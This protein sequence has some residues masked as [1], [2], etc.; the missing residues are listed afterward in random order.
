MNALKL[1]YPITG[2]LLFTFLV[3]MSACD[4]TGSGEEEEEVITP[5]EHPFYAGY[6]RADMNGGNDYNTTSH[7]KKEPAQKSSIST[8]TPLSQ[9]NEAAKSSANGYYLEFYRPEDQEHYIGISNSNTET[10]SEISWGDEI[11]ITFSV[12][13][14]GTSTFSVHLG[15]Y[16]PAE[17]VIEWDGEEYDSIPIEFLEANYYETRGIPISDFWAEVDMS[18][19]THEIELTLVVPGQTSTTIMRRFQIAPPDI[20]AEKFDFAEKTYFIENNAE[21]IYGDLSVS[22]NTLYLDG[23]GTLE[24]VENNE[25][26]MIVSVSLDGAHKEKNV[27]GYHVGLK[28]IPPTIPNNAT[29]NL[30]VDRGWILQ[31]STKNSEEGDRWFFMSSGNYQFVYRWH[32]ANVTKSWGYVSPTQIKFGFTPSNMP[33]TTDIVELTS[34]RMVMND[35]AQEYIFKPE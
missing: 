9:E 19:G 10:E 13:N 29:T 25:D 30:M 12:L 16:E 2:V 7:K 22:G 31:K 35:G 18:P 3:M 4:T 27:S 33:G 14:S 32:E 24:V 5:V 15:G 20:Q 11:N 28:K 6:W 26:Q 21:V 1:I 17:V 8:V 23:Y 34:T